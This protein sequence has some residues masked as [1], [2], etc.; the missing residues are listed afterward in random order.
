MIIKGGNVFCIMET[1]R[2]DGL[3]YQGCFQKKDIYIDS[4]KSFCDE[5]EA[6]DG[7]IIDAE[8]FYVIPGLVDIHTHGC[9]GHDFCDADENGL[10]AIAAYQHNTG[11]TSFLPTS[12]TLPEERLARIFAAAGSVPDDGLHAWV[13]GINMEGPFVAMEKRGAQ[14]P[15]YVMDPHEE[16]LARLMKEAAVP[17]RLMTLAPELPGAMDL[18]RRF[19]DKLHISLGHSA[20]AYEDAAKAFELG[21]DHITHLYNAMLPFAHREPGIIGAGAER[22][23][24][25]AELICDGLHVHPSAVRASFAMF[26]P[27]RIVLISDSMRAAGLEDGVSEL[28]GQT[29]YKRG[30]RAALKDGTLAGSVSNLMVCLRQAVAFGIPL[31]DAVMAA[32]YNPARSIGLAGRIG[33]IR[34]GARGDAVLLDRKL[35]IIKVI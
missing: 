15:A 10:R 29:V 2:E 1:E 8:G 23:D 11:V 22:R 20:A 5:P 7:N 34:P 3:S 30:F 26:G 13:A 27:D 21:A 4:G 35:D 17:V 25:F 18:I 6:G 14:N 9:M 12:M 28:G 33:V 24:V 32:S 31:E 16:M 19:H